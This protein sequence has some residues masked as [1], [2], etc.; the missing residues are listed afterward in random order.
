M[1]A[2]DV[3]KSEAL[4]LVQGIEA[5]DIPLQIRG[6]LIQ[7]P[8]KKLTPDEVEAMKRLYAPVF[9]LLKDRQAQAEAAAL[10]LAAKAAAAAARAT[11]P[12]RKRG[13][14]K[15]KPVPETGQEAPARRPRVPR[16]G[17]TEDLLRRFDIWLHGDPR[18]KGKR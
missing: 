9:A 3:L 15:A 18:R 10:E 4:A 2:L 13:T 12:A 5:R 8:A 17:P 1:D 6:Q 11:R 7:V 14:L 16:L